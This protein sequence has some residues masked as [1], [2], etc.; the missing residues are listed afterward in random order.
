M[1]ALLVATVAAILAT[2]VNAFSY[3]TPIPVTFESQGADRAA[4]ET[5]L[6]T[7]TAAVS[8][9]NQAL[10]ETLLLSKTI[11]FSGVPLSARAGDVAPE[12]TNYEAFRR[13]VFQG[14]PFVQK[15]Q[16]VH[17]QQDGSLAQVSLVFVNTTPKEVSWGW[18]TMQLLK[19]GGKWKIAGEFFTAHD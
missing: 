18:K 5:L 9:K 2:P 10:F 8:H 16:N 14:S 13:A 12:T 1:K 11:P 17:I 15:F 3:R 4:I 6:N 7:Y 19:V